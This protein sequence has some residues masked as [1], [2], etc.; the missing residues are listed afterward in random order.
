MKKL[1]T[2]MSAPFLEPGTPATSGCSGAR[3][4]LHFL[5][6]LALILLV[7]PH[8]PSQVLQGMLPDPDSYMRLVRMQEALDGGRWF[9]DVVSRDASGDGLA[10]HWSHAIDGVILFL[11]APLCLLLEPQEALLW[12]GAIIGPLFVGLLG[13][14][15]AWAAAP[16]APRGWLW[17][18]PLAIALSPGIAGYGQLG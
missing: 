16:L 2:S 6:A 12:A 7:R 15:C 3:H 18:A 9:G 13:L 5:I 4:A 17:V 11:R 1:A 14:C 8:N 10:L